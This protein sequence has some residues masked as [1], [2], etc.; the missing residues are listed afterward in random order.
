MIEDL[1]FSQHLR[2]LALAM[3]CRNRAHGVQYT[4]DITGNILIPTSS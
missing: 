4:L 1:R 2:W 3:F